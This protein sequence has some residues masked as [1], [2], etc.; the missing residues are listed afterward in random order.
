LISCRAFDLGNVSMRE[1]RCAPDWIADAR[2]F[3]SISW[4]RFGR[5]WTGQEFSRG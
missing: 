1:A 2:R 4:M 3:S 5:S